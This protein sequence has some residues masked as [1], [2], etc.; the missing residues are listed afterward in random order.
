MPPSRPR[1]IRLSGGASTSSISS[2]VRR[3][4]VGHAVARAFAGDALDV[5]LL[6]GDVLQVDR[7]DDADAV[8]QQFLDV[9]PALL[10]PAAG[11][12]VVSQTVDQADLRMAADDRRQVHGSLLVRAG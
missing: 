6:L 3:N 8:L 9:L 10:V 7:G 5:V 12:I 11:R 2:A 4:A 1:S